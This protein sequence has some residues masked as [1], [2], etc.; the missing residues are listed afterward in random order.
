MT[1][2]F[3]KVKGQADNTCGVSHIDGAKMRCGS[4]WLQFSNVAY[5]HEQA[6]EALFKSGMFVG[7][8][9]HEE[10]LW[11]ITTRVERQETLSR[12]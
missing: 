2:S 12:N 5:T 9:L 8:V 7:E 3:K 6:I 4:I 10:V 11:R 1:D